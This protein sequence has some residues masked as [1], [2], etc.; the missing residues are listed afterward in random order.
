MHS[1]LLSYA[2]PL[3]IDSAALRRQ[4]VSS[5]TTGGLPGPATM[6]RFVAFSAARATAGPPVT[7]SR[8]VPRWLKIASAVSSVGGTMQVIRWSIPN[9]AA[10]ALLYS[11]TAWAAQ[12]V[13]LGCGLATIELPAAI[14]LIA[15]ADSVGTLCVT[16]VMMPITPNGANSS[17]HR[18]LEPLVA[19]V[20]R[21]S[22]PGTSS[23]IWSFSTL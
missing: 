16:G 18:P 6:A 17:M 2:A 5:T 11:R 15:L 23:R 4:A 14:M 3:T 7:T 19:L 8:G 20:W 22:T 1:R 9:F 10:I 21:N 13:P 12:L